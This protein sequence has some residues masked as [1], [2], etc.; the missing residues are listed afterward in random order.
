MFRCFCLSRW[1]SYLL[2]YH[3]M[4][5]PHAGDAGMHIGC[6]GRP[7]SQKPCARKSLKMNREVG[8]LTGFNAMPP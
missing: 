7:D 2:L 1:S 6:S 5:I 8:R 4:T 3:L